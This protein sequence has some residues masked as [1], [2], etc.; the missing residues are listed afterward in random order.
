MVLQTQDDEEEKVQPKQRL[1]PTTSVVGVTWMAGVVRLALAPVWFS[2]A[3]LDSVALLCLLRPSK[4]SLVL[5][6]S[7][8]PVTHNPRVLTDAEAAS[9]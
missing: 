5:L 1:A 9:H 3:L 4:Q 8:G 2:R 6:V 7:T